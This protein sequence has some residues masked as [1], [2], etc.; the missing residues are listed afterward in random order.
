MDLYAREKYLETQILTATPQRLRLMLI[1][2]A[3]RQARAA[4]AAWNGGHST[5][6]IEAVG[7]CRSII[8]ELSAG[9]RPEMTPE[10]KQL[11]A[12]YMFLFA[13]L[14]FLLI[15]RPPRRRR[16]K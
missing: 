12:V 6:A 15:R 11:L 13:T 4:Q 7:N 3:I 10:A 14:V 8:S 1:E 16:R 2:G 9:I 5:K